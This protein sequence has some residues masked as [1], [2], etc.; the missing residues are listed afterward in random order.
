MSE[1]ANTSAPKTNAAASGSTTEA[2]PSASASG[3]SGNKKN[4]GTGANAGTAAAASG[5]SSEAAPSASASAN[6]GNKKNKGTGANAAAASGSTTE[7]APSANSGNKK[8]KGTGANA[9]AP[10]ETNAPPPEDAS[11]QEIKDA[12]AEL[13]KIVETDGSSCSNIKEKAK[14]V[15]N[16]GEGSIATALKN[17]KIKEEQLAA[18]TKNIK[19]ILDPITKAC[20]N[21]SA[22]PA[23]EGGRRKQ[24]THK[25]K[26]RKSRSKSRRRV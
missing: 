23:M 21:S 2:A 22:K 24:K 13:K 3:N 17:N 12:V 18:V 20:K 5:A 10:S 19:A 26:S 16:V 7:A 1:G 15:V 6:S 4:K 9:E 14:V 11:I 8:N 25:R